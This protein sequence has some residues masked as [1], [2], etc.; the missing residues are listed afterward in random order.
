MILRSKKPLAR[1]HELFRRLTM[2]CSEPAIALRSSTRLVGLRSLAEGMAFNSPPSKQ[3]PVG[4]SD[5][6]R[7][8]ASQPF[9][10]VFEDDG[11]EGYLYGSTSQRG[12]AIVTRCSSTKYSRFRS[13]TSRLG[14]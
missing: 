2:R 7:S 11:E 12:N 13:E 3:S 6:R 8:I 5:C 9:G 14:R 10:V 4:N 1:E